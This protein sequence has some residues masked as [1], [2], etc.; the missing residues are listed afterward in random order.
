MTYNMIGFKKINLANRRIFLIIQE[1][2]M[3]I[4]FFRYNVQRKNIFI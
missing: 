2:K 1:K 4:P 3:M